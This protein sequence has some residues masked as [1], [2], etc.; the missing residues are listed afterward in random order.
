[1]HFSS[2]SEAAAAAV[3]LTRPMLRLTFVQ[4]TRMQRSLKTIRTL[5]C[6]YSLDS[7]R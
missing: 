1:M 3:A 2:A 7:S 6:E 5:S 4:T